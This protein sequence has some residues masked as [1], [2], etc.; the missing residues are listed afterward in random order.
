MAPKTIRIA[1]LINTYASTY[2]PLV[3]DSF[4][5]AITK[6]SPS[7]E[8]E[9]FDPIQLHDYPDIENG[10]YDLI[11]LSGGSEDPMGD[12]PWVLKEISWI[13]ETIQNWPNQKIMGVCW[14]HQ[15]IC[16]AFGGKVERMEEAELGVSTV[17][18]TEFGAQ[19]FSKALH[20]SELRI[21]EYHRRHITL[22]AKGFVTLAEGNQSF[23]SA[24]NTILSFQGH[25]EMN[26]EL[27]KTMFSKVPSYMGVDKRDK[28]SI[29]DR[30]QLD[31]D[32]LKI[33]SKVLDWTRE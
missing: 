8:V 7:A 9:F 13:K 33:W 18:L 19:F 23:V 28:P 22:P 21:H 16:R 30:M 27:V 32:G 20:S 25:P 31:H 3:R 15:L 29:L 11:V 24:S 12:A 5:S 17:A 26:V 2:L 10:R 4:T 1:I 6:L 14:G